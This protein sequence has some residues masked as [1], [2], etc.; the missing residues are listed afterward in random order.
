MS[1]DVVVAPVVGALLVGAAIGGALARRAFK[2][3]GPR[4]AVA[5][6]PAN[7]KPAP[8]GAPPI[9]PASQG[10]SGMDAALALRD[11]TARLRALLSRAETGLRSARRDAAAAPPPAPAPVAPDP[12]MVETLRARIRQLEEA[13]DDQPAPA[14]VEERVEAPPVGPEFRAYALP[15]IERLRVVPAR[16]GAP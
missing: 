15:E 14:T 10:A 8:T 6:R 4:P 13:L 16:G 1:F 11:E 7:A 2:H 9:P 12:A 5:A 3:K